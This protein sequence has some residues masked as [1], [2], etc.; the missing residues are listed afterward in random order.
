M[1]T[2]AERFW[3]KVDK[4]KECWEWTSALGTSGYGSFSAT[5][6]GLSRSAQAHRVSWILANG[7][8]P[9][10]LYVLHKCD[11][12]R[13][14]NPAHLFLGSHLD[15]MVDKVRK[16]RQSRGTVHSSTCRGELVGNS[17]LTKAM[18]ISI[19][20]DPRPKTTIAADYGITQGLVSYIKNRKIWRHLK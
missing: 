6:I 10:A 13:C 11:N 17:K 19:R 15:N 2:L 8:I 3:E 12:R 16:S 7:A 9:K 4:T 5:S 18:V 20:L 1:K 14:V